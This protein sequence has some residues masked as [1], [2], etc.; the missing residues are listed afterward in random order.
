MNSLWIAMVAIMTL[1]L[2]C[3][4]VPVRAEVASKR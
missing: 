3:I 1:A 4:F 2:G